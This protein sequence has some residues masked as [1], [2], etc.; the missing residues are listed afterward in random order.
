MTRRLA[1]AVPVALLAFVLLPLASAQPAGDGAEADVANLPLGKDAWDLRAL[2]DEPVKLVKATYDADRRV[3]RIIL[4][5][6]RD[7]TVRDT[8]WRGFAVRPP[9]WFRFQDADGA[10]MRSEGAEF[11]SELIGLKGRRVRVVL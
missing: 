8:D 1:A 3:V 2:N 11:G 7:L 10:T 6:Q 9:F 4:E 5:F